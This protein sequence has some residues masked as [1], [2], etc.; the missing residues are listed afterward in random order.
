[1]EGGR[2]RYGVEKERQTGEGKERERESGGEIEGRER[3]RA[4]GFLALVSMSVF[5]RLYPVYGETSR[6]DDCIPR[7]RAWHHSL[8]SLSRRW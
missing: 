2:E 6:A 4:I 3:E 7:V 5:A 8:L 1:M